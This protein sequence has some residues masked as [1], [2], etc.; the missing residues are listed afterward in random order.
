MKSFAVASERCAKVA[1]TR[2][3]DDGG[4]A[5]DAVI[6]GFFA[7]AG[8]SDAALFS[9][10]Q[11]L[12]AGPGVGARAFDGRARQPGRGL[13]RPRGLLEGQAVVPA[14][15]IAVPASL[16]ALSLA[17]AYDGLLSIARLA[18]PGIAQARRCAK[19]AR[20]Q[21]MMRVAA[22]GAAALRDARIARPLLAMGGR[23]QGGLLSEQDLF[24]LRPASAAPR[25]IELVPQDGAPDGERDRCVLVVP[26]HE[27]ETV[28]RP[29]QIVAAGDPRGVVAVL[30]WAPDDE[31]VWVPELELRAP[32][33]AVVVRRGVA[34]IRPGEPIGCPASIAIATER[35]RPVLAMGLGV[36]RALPSGMLERVWGARLAPAAMLRAA[37]QAMAAP[38]AV[39]IV[40]SMGKNQ[41]RGL[42]L[43][44]EPPG[45]VRRRGEER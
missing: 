40:R 34:R 5:I 43:S 18:L 2:A 1:A 15:R 16:A 6:A 22:A 30:A 8:A 13:P 29:Q 26:W 17:H 39:A 24:E 9:P 27:P 44:A 35:D 10:L 3:L 23:A 11:A 4:T 28:H 32:R 45:G 37:A 33:E 31:G 25:R 41:M 21:V 36:D 42:T 38:E 12:V 14:A 20:E 19:R 7:A